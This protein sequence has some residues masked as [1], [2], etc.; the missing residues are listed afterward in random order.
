MLE[1]LVLHKWSILIIAEVFSYV[2]TVGIAVFRYLKPQKFLFIVCCIFS[3]ITGWCFDLILPI[4]QYIYI[5]DL[6]EFLS[7]KSSMAFNLFIIILFILSIIFG[8]NLIV[9]IDNFFLK[10]SEEIKNKKR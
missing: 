7:S 8:K 6:K 1:F 5:G 9:K 2:F 10:K 3:F 4:A